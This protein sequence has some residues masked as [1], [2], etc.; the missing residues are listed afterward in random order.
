LANERKAIT[1]MKAESE[2][3]KWRHQYEKAIGY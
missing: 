3:K 2:E 1:E